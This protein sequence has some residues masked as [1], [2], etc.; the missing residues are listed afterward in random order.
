MELLHGTSR[1][2]AK[3]ADGPLQWD[4]AVKIIFIQALFP[5]LNLQRTAIGPL[6][7]KRLFKLNFSSESTPGIKVL[8]YLPV[9]DLEIRGVGGGG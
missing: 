2:P 6:A 4:E 1:T 7:E 9:A 8:K 5:S 3:S